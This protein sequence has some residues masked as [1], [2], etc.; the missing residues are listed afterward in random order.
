MKSVN[1]RMIGYFCFIIFSDFVV[2]CKV[3]DEDE[4]DEFSNVVHCLIDM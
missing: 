4:K 2:E 3:K 1:P